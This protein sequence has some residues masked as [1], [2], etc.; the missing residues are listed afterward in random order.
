MLDMRSDG[1]FTQDKR[2]GDVSVGESAGDERRNLALARAQFARLPARATLRWVRARC[3]VRRRLEGK[4]QRI[5]ELNGLAGRP[6]TLKRRGSERL[7]RHLHNFL[8]V[9]A[10]CRGQR[11]AESLALRS[12]HTAQ[13]RGALRLTA[14]ARDRGL[15]NP[16]HAYTSTDT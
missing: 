11:R 1:P 9:L 12:R 8:G 10:L 4:C 2:F 13:T 16:P 5:V 3:R 15:I 6:L 7:R 14:Q